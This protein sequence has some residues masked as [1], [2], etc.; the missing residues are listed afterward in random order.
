[1]RILYSESSQFQ[2]IMLTEKNNEV[3]LALDGAHQTVLPNDE[4]YQIILGGITPDMSVAVLG[5]GDLTGVRVLHANYNTWD[6]YEIDQKVMDVCSP[7]VG[8]PRSKWARHVHT[9]DALQGLLD[10]SITADAI[11]VDLLAMTQIDKLSHVMSPAKFLDVVCQNARVSVSGFSA[12]NAV[13]IMVNELLRHEFA[14]RGF[15]HFVS[16]MDTLEEAYFCASKEPI[17]VADIAA[18]HVVGYP[19][20]PK[21]GRIMELGFED[22]LTVLKEAF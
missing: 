18:Q 8:V 12:A 19:I 10:G 2:H 1:M 16:F 7:Y 13:G 11:V 22:Q 9:C 4:Y 20:Y 3:S 14:R 21:S 5:G 6:I 15:N 17:T